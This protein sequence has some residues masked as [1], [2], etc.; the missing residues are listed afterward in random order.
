MYL[1]ALIYL[2]HNWSFTPGWSP[3]YLFEVVFVKL[4][5][6]RFSSSFM[7][8]FVGLYITIHPPFFIIIIIT[9]IQSHTFAAENCAIGN[10]VK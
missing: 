10:I 4:G 1:M 3:A 6:H 9:I 2:A 7:G 5:E 8:F